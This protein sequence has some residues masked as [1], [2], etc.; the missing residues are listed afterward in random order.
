MENPW[1]LLVMAILMGTAI[2]V[3]G[4]VTLKIIGV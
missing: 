3:A 1:T 2:V 4:T